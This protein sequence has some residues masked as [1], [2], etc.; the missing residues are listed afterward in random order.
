M[1]QP[2]TTE[3]VR[4]TPR[5]VPAAVAAEWTRIVRRIACRMAKRLPRS[6]SIDDLISAG[7]LGLAQALAAF[8]PEHRE[9]WEAYATKRVRGAMLDELRALD[10]LSRQQ[11]R[12]VGRIDQAS[13]RLASELGRWPEPEEISEALQ[14]TNDSYHKAVAYAQTRVSESIDSVGSIP[15]PP[16]VHDHHDDPW[17]AESD[18]MRRQEAARVARAVD[19]LP[20]RLRSVIGFYFQEGLTLREISEILGVTE[21]RVHQLR[22]EALDL[23]RSHCESVPPPAPVREAAPRRKTNARRAVPVLQTA[24]AA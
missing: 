24:T 18:A 2:A 6:V 17:S 9:S 1:S 7:N 4:T 16:G 11:R 12:T 14:L 23:L 13:R 22:N 15:A 5:T 8:D 19:D 21:P 20:E 3:D 10:P